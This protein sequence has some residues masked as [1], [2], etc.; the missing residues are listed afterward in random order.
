MPDGHQGDRRP[1]TPSPSQPQTG[2]SPQAFN[3]PGATNPAGGVARA[4][5]FVRSLSGKAVVLAVVVF[6]F[7][8]LMP[9]GSKPSS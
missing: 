9:A 3:I 4:I 2:A 7:Q 8:A 1:F 5:G 6:G